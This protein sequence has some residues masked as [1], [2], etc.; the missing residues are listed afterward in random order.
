MLTGNWS[1]PPSA[2]LKLN[3]SLLRILAECSAFRRKNSQNEN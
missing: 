2:Y 1:A 3:P